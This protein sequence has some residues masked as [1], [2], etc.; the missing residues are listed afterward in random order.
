MT[1]RS[2][3]LVLAL[4]AAPLHAAG[5]MDDALGLYQAKRYPDARAAFEAITA[6][7]AR[8]AEARYYLGVLAQKRN[9]TDEAVRR[10]EEAT[11]L[12]PTKSAYFTE[13]GGAYGTAAGHA[14]LFAKVGFAQKCQAALARAVELDP[15]NLEARNGLVSF[16]RSAPT[17]VGGGMSKAYA[18]AEEIRRRN[19]I[20]GASVLGQLYLA[21]QKFEPAFTLYE[22]TL[23]TAPDH[24]L[25]LY[26]IG[27]AAAQ[28][29]LHL[30]RGEEVLHRC[31]ALKPGPG[32][33]G[34][35]PVQWRLGNIAE[36]RGDTPAARA[37]YAA[38]LKEDPDFT[39]ARDALAKL[40]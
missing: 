24:Y 40:K 13:L 27:R 16:Y 21:E 3:L 12:D 20:V 2:V 26:A 31:L 36:K 34:H 4:A 8:N 10:L 19:P 33:P 9:D 32:E 17:F 30:D 6:R 23:K 7:D 25:L 1:P 22:E 35:A 14:G 15:N 29:G 5:P 28:T 37:A 11:A 18:E 38:A 39:Q